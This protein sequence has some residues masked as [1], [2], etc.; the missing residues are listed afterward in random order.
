MKENDRGRGGDRMDRSNTTLV[1]FSASKDG[2]RGRFKS[3]REEEPKERIAH[4]EGVTRESNK[5][6]ASKFGG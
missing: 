2:V 1:R 3:G 6:K 5:K 4:L